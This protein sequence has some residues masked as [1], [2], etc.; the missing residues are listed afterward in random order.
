LNENERKPLAYFLILDKGR[1]L[2]RPVY[3]NRLFGKRL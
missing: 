3:T 1:K 2:A